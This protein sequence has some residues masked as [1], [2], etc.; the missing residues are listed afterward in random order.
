MLVQKSSDR[1]L[2]NGLH[3]GVAIECCKL[4]PT[5]CVPIE[6]DVDEKAGALQARSLDLSQRLACP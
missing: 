4:Q 6:I 2:R 1:L 3:G 5:L